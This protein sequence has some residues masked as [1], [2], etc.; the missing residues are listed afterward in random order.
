MLR[1][2]AYSHAGVQRFPVPRTAAVIGSAG[3]CEIC[4]QQAGIAARHAQLSWDGDELRIADLGS[5]RGLVVNGRRVE[6][7]G[8]QVLDEIKLGGTTLLLE[9]VGI[10]GSPAPGAALSVPDVPTGDA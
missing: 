4:I 1:F 5:R 10:S 9:D 3:D 2:V 8:L 7:A 6:E